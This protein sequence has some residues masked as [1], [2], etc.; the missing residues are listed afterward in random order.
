VDEADDHGIGER[1]DVKVGQKRFTF[2]LRIASDTIPA[3]PS[4]QLL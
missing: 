2:L 4:S 3:E 1:L